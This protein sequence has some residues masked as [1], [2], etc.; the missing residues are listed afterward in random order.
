MFEVNLRGTKFTSN[1]LAMK[2]LL[3]N[4]AGNNRAEILADGSYYLDRNPL[5]FITF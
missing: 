3:E 4:L 5:I 1:S 2:H